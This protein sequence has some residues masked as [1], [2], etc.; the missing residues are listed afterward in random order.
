MLNLAKIMDISQ[1]SVKK[2]EKRHYVGASSIGAMCPRKVWYSSN[3]F[4]GEACSPE[5]IRI[6]DTGHLL[7]K[8]LCDYIQNNLKDVSLISGCSEELSLK[9]KHYDFFQGHADGLLIYKKD[10][11]ILE[12][13]TLSATGFNTLKR[14][15]L[16]SFS[17][18]YYSQVQSYMGMSGIKKAILLAINKNN[19]ELYSETI[20]FNDDFYFSLQ[21]KAL[22]IYESQEAPARIS[23]DGLHIEC[24]KCTFK[25]QC[26]KI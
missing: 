19:S 1:K 13:K 7:E 20:E 9:D 10:K 6:F 11:Y 18:I 26:F 25:N 15:G 8:M 23:K 22:F 12:I 21:A 16:F 5:L 4:E 2:K 24:K 17:E 14:K 3:G